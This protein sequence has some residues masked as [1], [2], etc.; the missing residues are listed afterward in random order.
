MFQLNI[1]SEAKVTPLQAFIIHVVA[2]VTIVAACTVL[3]VT[4][5]ISGGD[6]LAI[7]GTVTGGVVGSGISASGANQGA[8]AASV[9]VQAAPQPTHV[10]VL[11]S[12][13]APVSGAS[14]VEVPASSSVQSAG[15]VVN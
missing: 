4:R 6:A 14:V 5:V 13:T 7:I 9:Q 3:A 1:G 12:P 10:T 2:V 11:S 8:K 15:S